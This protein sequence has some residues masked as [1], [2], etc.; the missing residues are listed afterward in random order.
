LNCHVQLGF[1]IGDIPNTR[2]HP[3]VYEEKTDGKR[4]VEKFSLVNNHVHNKQTDTKIEMTTTLSK[5]I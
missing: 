4:I 3:S 5:E 2:R 1:G